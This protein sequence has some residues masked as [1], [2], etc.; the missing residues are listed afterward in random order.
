MY[1]LKFN[2]FKIEI[3]CTEFKREGFISFAVLKHV[4]LQRQI[5]SHYDGKLGEAEAQTAG[6]E[7]C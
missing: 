5:I 3:T 6:G 4:R 1:K 2:F 7:R